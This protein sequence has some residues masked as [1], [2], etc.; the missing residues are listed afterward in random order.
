MVAKAVATRVSLI[1]SMKSKIFLNL[2]LHNTHIVQLGGL[3]TT[4]MQDHCKVVLR[5]IVKIGMHPMVIDRSG[6]QGGVGYLAGEVQMYTNPNPRGSSFLLVR[7]VPNHKHSCRL[8]LEQMDYIT[9]KDPIPPASQ[10]REAQG[11]ISSNS[12]VGRQR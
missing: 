8:Q 5:L 12:G 2:S 9:T 1:L 11:G 7:Q 10:V 3:L 6:G 4:A